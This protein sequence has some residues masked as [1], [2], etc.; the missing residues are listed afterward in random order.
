MPSQAGLS[1][2][3]PAFPCDLDCTAHLYCWRSRKDVTDLMQGYCKG[4]WE[5]LLVLLLWC[6]PPVD[7]KRAYRTSRSFKCVLVEQPQFVQVYLNSWGIEICPVLP[8]WKLAPSYP[9]PTLRPW[10][11]FSLWECPAD[12]VSLFSLQ[13]VHWV[14]SPT[15][16]FWAFH[17]LKAAFLLYS[18][19]NCYTVVSV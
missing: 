15:N 4:C 2:C 14:L 1:H 10:I 7:D 5:L 16:N 9:C 11:Y 6:C 19:N 13:E 12:L 18:Y 17:H 3:V 8:L